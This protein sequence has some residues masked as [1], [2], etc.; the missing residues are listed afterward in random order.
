MAELPDFAALVC[1]SLTPD[2]DEIAASVTQAKRRATLSVACHHEQ[3]YPEVCY[4]S[5]SDA[6]D[7][8]KLTRPDSS[9][10]PRMHA[11]ATRFYA[12]Y[13]LQ[14]CVCCGGPRTA[15]L[16]SLDKGYRNEQAVSSVARFLT[17]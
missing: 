5:P 3:L 1:R 12:A 4:S 9:T 14:S 2:T 16:G 17:R 11:V 8:V 10:I 7:K 13:L 6:D 15:Q